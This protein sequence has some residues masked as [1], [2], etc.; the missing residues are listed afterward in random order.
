M[1]A[2]QLAY[3][4]NEEIRRSDNTDSLEFHIR[5]EAI[6]LEGDDGLRVPWTLTVIERDWKYDFFDEL[7][8]LDEY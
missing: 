3:D 2:F 6:E 1:D 8:E 4:L 7:D 5:Q